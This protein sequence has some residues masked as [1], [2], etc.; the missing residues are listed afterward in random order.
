MAIIEVLKYSGKKDVFAW[1]YPSEEL[2]LGTQ[3]IV[4]ESQEVVFV[5][6]GK[7]L[8]I[9]GPGRHTLTTANIPILSN[10]INLPFGGKTPFTA[11]VWYINKAYLLDIK[12]GTPSPIQLQDPKYKVFVPVRAF[13]QLGIQIKD[14]KKFLT[15]IVGTLGV[16]QQED[17]VSY[18]RG[19]IV[20]NVKDTISSY[21]VQKQ[22]SI[23]EINAYI[24]EI[25]EQLEQNM[26]Q[27]IEEYGVGISN[28]YIT[29]IDMPEE[30]EAVIQLKQALAKR[31]EMDIVGYDY[32]QERS[33]DTLEGAAKNPSSMGSNIMGAGIGLGMG[34]GV[35]GAFGA[36]MESVT[37]SMDMS[38]K[39]KDEK[40]C[41]DCEAEIKK[42]QK[43]CSKC[44]RQLAIFCKKC[45]E[46][47]EQEEKFCHKCGES[48][49]IECPKCKIEIKPGQK[50]C[51]NCGEKLENE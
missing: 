11:E 23:L 29:S 45:G 39:E 24:N 16:F 6:E 2:G 46:T 9:L 42:N 43:F 8:D 33:F 31:A 26:K 36:Q 49:F 19:L 44:G 18:F 10:L 34:L 4:N 15:K 37:Q 20:S 48:Q 7:I 21:L 27:D 28:F 40:K 17:M 22:I 35:G 13:G 1:R 25:S 38:H 50:F 47:L 14:S 3:V 30:D 41:P 5:K 32:K 12:W 51:P